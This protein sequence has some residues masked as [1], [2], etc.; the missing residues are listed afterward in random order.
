MWIR[1]FS[2]CSAA[3]ENRGNQRN[4]LRMNSP[5]RL[6]MDKHSFLRWAEGREGH[7]EL[8]GQVVSMM[9]GASRNHSRVIKGLMG[10]LDSRI[11]QHRFEVMPTDLAVEIGDDIRYPDVIVDPAGGEGRD[12]STDRPILV[13]EVLS[14][15]S[16]AL[17][18]HI[19]AAEY[20]SLSSLEC[21]IVAAQDEPRLWIWNRGDMAA[22]RA[23]PKA[24]LEVFGK[25]K[26][27]TI[28]ALGLDAPMAE[29]Y[30][31]IND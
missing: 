20:M 17:D 5:V 18:L 26:V 31:A 2:A 30:A 23:W 15:S 1:F 7:Y 13:A 12:L 14:P 25:D 16:I 10:A 19:K 21:Y 8:K 4:T 27:V 28:P 9:T 6:T 29:I 24:P 3:V 11:D 22:G